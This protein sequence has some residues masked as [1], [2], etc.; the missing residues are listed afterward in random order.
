[1]KPSIGHSTKLQKFKKIPVSNMIMT[2]MTEVFPCFFLV[3][4]ANA[5][6]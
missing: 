4:K 5:R 2:T 3:C 6:V 1:M